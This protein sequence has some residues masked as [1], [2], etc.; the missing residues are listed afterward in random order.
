MQVCPFCDTSFDDPTNIC[1]VC[2]Y[3]FSLP[4]P[5]PRLSHQKLYFTLSLL[6]ILSGILACLF[7][8]FTNFYFK[9]LFLVL[10]SIGLAGTTL[11]RARGKSGAFWIRILALFGLVCG[12]LGYIFY[13]FIHSNVPGIGYSM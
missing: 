2:G 4:L 3:S 9:S 7:I 10:V 12:V 13:M 1:K 5:P 11:E 8:F 6:S